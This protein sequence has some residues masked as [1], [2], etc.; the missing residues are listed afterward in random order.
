MMYDYIITHET[1]KCHWI[2]KRH[3]ELIWDLTLEMDIIHRYKNTSE[4]HRARIVKRN[5]EHVGMTQDGLFKDK[6]FKVLDPISVHTVKDKGV[7]YDSKDRKKFLDLNYKDTPMYWNI[8]RKQES[9]KDGKLEKVTLD[10][11]PECPMLFPHQTQSNY[12]FDGVDIS[13]RYS[14]H[15][16]VVPFKSDLIEC[17]R[18]QSYFIDF[19]FL[20]KNNK[21]KLWG[22]LDKNVFEENYKIAEKLHQA[23]IKFEY[24]DLDKGDFTKRFQVK[25]MLS[26]IITHPSI[27]QLKTL[28]NKKTAR[29]NYKTITNIAKEYLSTKN[30]KDNRL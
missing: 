14:E 22:Y 10:D 18:N 29:E 7:C 12:A 25:K 9:N 30:R 19:I 13:K 5:I 2:K 1:G 21:Q 8:L 27:V 11:V 3:H 26:R 16:N 20:Y 4:L 24:F 6:R 15:V 23:N 28:K 17:C